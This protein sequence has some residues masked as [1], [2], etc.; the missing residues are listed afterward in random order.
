MKYNHRVYLVKT[1]LGAPLNSTFSLYK[2]DILFCD[3]SKEI[4]GGM[5]PRTYF[6]K[7]ILYSF[8][9]KQ[10]LLKLNDNRSVTSLFNGFN[11]IPMDIL[12]RDGFLE[13]ITRDYKIEKILE[14]Q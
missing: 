9:N 7:E 12:L 1:E 11:L 2:G 6:V 8:N 5:L 13:D 4:V 10:H 3:K 14:K